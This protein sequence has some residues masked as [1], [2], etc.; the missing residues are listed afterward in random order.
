M[1][2][3]FSLKGLI[4][5]LFSAATMAGVFLIGYTAIVYEGRTEP[6]NEFIVGMFLLVPAVGVVIAFLLMV[7]FEAVFPKE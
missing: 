3:K 4:L 1:K 6:P 7:A 5:V 2:R